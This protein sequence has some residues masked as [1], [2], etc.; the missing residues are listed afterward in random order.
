MWLNYPS[1][2][3]DP[4][5]K[6]LTQ[7]LYQIDNILTRIQALLMKELPQIEAKKVQSVTPEVKKSLK[8]AEI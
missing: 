3:F 6:S 5:E 4:K 1:P 8:H 2:A 7:D